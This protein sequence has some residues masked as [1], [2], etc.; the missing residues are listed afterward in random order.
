[1]ESAV[2]AGHS[3]FRGKY[4]QD[5]ISN[6]GYLQVSYFHDKKWQIALF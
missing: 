6:L 1:M 2:Y 5:G 3:N 4:G